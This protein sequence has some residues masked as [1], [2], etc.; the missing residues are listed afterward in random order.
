MIE[1]NWD[2]WIKRRFSDVNKYLLLENTEELEMIVKSIDKSITTEI[3]F[4][5]MSRDDK[6]VL[7]DIQ[8]SGGGEGN[9]YN[10]WVSHFTTD[11]MYQPSDKEQRE[12][13][14]FLHTSLFLNSEFINR[15]EKEWL[16]IPLKQGWYEETIFLGS[17]I[18]FSRMRISNLRNTGW[19][20]VIY[21]FWQLSIWHIF[22]LFKLRIKKNVCKAIEPILPPTGSSVR[23]YP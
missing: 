11:P 6:E 1:K 4:V 21:N 8:F 16:I 10:V 20:K 17:K 2:E 5:F 13:N 23:Y 18:I 22:I 12:T 7:Y 14:G 19:D 3:R 15:L 9:Q